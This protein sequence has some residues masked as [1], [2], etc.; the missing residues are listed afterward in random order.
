MTNSKIRIRGLILMLVFGGIFSVFAFWIANPSSYP[1]DYYPKGPG[2][3]ILIGAPG[4][5]VAFTAIAV[6]V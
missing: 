2:G 1:F 5:A 6:I 4:G 3:A